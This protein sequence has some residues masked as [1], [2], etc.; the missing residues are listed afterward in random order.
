MKVSVWRSKKNLIR[1][2]KNDNYDIW[3]SDEVHFQ[4]YGSGCRMWVPPEVKKPILLHH[5]TR[6]SVGY[7]GAV[8]LR[9]GKFCF[10]REV[11]TFNGETFY[12]FLRRFHRQACRSGRQIILILDNARFHHA[13]LHKE[14]R[15]EH[16]NTMQILYLPPYSPD[17]NPIER[18][19]KLTRR[20]CIHNKYFPTVDD[21]ISSVESQFKIW[22]KPN[23]TLRKLCAI[24]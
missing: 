3:F 21:V 16:Q 13:R 10:Q 1:L 20:L 23:S 7:F 5:P 14:W 17:L 6:E 22:E 15:Q 8:R 2:A 19:W 9:D 24:I 18:M 4:Q 12:S 11:D